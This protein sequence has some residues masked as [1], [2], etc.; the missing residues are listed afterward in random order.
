[1]VTIV[2]LAAKGLDSYINERGTRIMDLKGVEMNKTVSSKKMDSLCFIILLWLLQFSNLKVNPINWF[3]DPILLVS[4]SSIRVLVDVLNTGRLATSLGAPYILKLFWI[5]QN[6]I[7]SESISLPST[8]LLLLV[9][10]GLC[11]YT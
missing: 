1:M 2:G 7:T 9:S 10:I 8:N 11:E 4:C 6:K 5:L 3:H